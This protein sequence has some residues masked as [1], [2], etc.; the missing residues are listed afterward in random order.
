MVTRLTI[1]DVS[2]LTPIVAIGVQ[3]SCKL[4]HFFKILLL[5]AILKQGLLLIN[6]RNIIS[7]IIMLLNI[8]ATRGPTD[9]C[10]A[11]HGLLLSEATGMGCGTRS[12]LYLIV[13]AVSRR[14]L[15]RVGYFITLNGR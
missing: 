15:S 11:T 9:C 14:G 12:P 5:F 4:T 1:I 6:P 8:N 2:V 3:I 7:N 10:S 13:D